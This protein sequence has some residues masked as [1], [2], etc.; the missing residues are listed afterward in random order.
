MG[1]FFARLNI[2]L[3][4][5][6]IKL[7][8]ILIFQ[9]PT[10]SISLNARCFQLTIIFFCLVDENL[11][12]INM[13]PSR[14]VF[15]YQCRQAR[16]TAARRRACGARPAA[17]WCARTPTRPGRA[18]RRSRRRTPCGTPLGTASP[19]KYCNFLYKLRI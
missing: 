11:S 13:E 5:V 10:M 16:A 6:Q 9:L 8:E 14:F 7:V 1:S 17:C 12:E 4:F 18:S 15:F 19:I 2:G 3:G